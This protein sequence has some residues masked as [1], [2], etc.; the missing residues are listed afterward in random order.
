MSAINLLR[1]QKGLQNTKLSYDYAKSDLFHII[2]IGIYMR[3]V[4]PS[5]LYYGVSN[6]IL[7][8]TVNVI[9]LK[10]LSFL[11]Y[12]HDNVGMST[13]VL[14]QINNEELII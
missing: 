5:Q 14:K 3:Q 11:Y 7:F 1:N 6:A 13:N 2:T 10:V 4:R 9:S 12:Y 8:G